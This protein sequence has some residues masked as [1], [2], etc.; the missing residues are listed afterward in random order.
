MKKIVLMIFTFS[1]L[2]IL[3]TFLNYENEELDSQIS[4]INIHN[5]KLENELI[6]LK[7]EW[8]YIN[9]PQNINFSLI[10]I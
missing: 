8:E 7:S 3:L 5:K 10:L 1:F 9:T 4:K 2:L 6:F